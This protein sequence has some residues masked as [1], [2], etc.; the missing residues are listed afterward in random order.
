MI[1]GAIAEQPLRRRPEGL[2]PAAAVDD[3]HGLG[4]AVEDRLQMRRARFGG[5]RI[6]RGQ[7][8]RSPQQFAAP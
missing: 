2:H 7:K 5:F 1:S 4:D 8:A 6:C 3:D